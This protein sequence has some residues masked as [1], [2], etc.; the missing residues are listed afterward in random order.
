M[1]QALNNYRRVEKET[2][3]ASVPD[4]PPRLLPHRQSQQQR[5]GWCGAGN[6]IASVKE[7]FFFLLVAVQVRQREGGDGLKLP[8]ALCVVSHAYVIEPGG[9]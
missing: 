3:L 6:G 2:K 8:S 1:L 4:L 7:F 9:K 5:D